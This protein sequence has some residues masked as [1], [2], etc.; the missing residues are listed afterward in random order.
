MSFYFRNIPDFEYVD[1]D[2]SASILDY[3]KVK[4]LFRKNK[5]RE[6]IFENLVYFTKYNIIGDERPDQVAEKFYDDATLDWVILLCN[7]IIDTRNEWPLDLYSFELNL[8]NN[9]DNIYG[10]HHYETKEIRTSSGILVLP[11]GLKIDKNWKTNG[12]FIAMNEKKITQIFCSIEGEV[13]VTLNDGLEKLQV[14]NSITISNISDSAYNGIFRVTSVFVPFQD[15]IATSFTYKI[16]TLPENFNPEVSNNNEV[17]SMVLND[18]SIV[19][20]NYYFEYYDQDNLTRLNSSGFLTEITNY[21]YELNLNNKKREIYIL[22][23]NYLGVVLNDVEKYSSYK[24]GGEQYIN[25]KLKRG[26]NIRL[27]S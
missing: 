10:V 19:G 26:D 17:A 18:G 2:N 7:N 25:E 24:L 11:Q 5:L 16:D 27:F 14:G 15:E 22:K 9:Y 12:N 4:N 21:D 1:P 3:I 8:Q 13:T 6:D 20:N 23:Q